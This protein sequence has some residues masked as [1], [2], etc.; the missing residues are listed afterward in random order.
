MIYLKPQQHQKETITHRTERSQTGHV[1]DG[2]RGCAGL[3]NDSTNEAEE[4][5]LVTME[6]AKI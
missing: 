4:R 2:N 3:V 6:R 5:P 1:L